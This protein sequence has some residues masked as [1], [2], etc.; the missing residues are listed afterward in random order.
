ME[1]ARPQ[2]GTRR[3][4]EFPGPPPSQ[5][6]GGRRN[7]SPHPGQGPAG[8]G[9]SPARPA[10]RGPW[11]VSPRRPCSV[12]L[13]PPPAEA[14]VPRAGSRWRRGRASLEGL[15]AASGSRCLGGHRVPRGPRGRGR[16]AARRR[17]AGPS[18][19]S[20]GRAAG[21]PGSAVS[22]ATGLLRRGPRGSRWREAAVGG[23]GRAGPGAAPQ[24][25]T[26]CIF[27]PWPQS[28]PAPRFERLHSLP[29]FVWETR[30][31]PALLA[32]SPGQNPG[33]P[34][35]DRC[36]PAS[37]DPQHLPPAP[38]PQG[39]GVKGSEWHQGRRRGGPVLPVPEHC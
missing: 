23:K 36:E 20:A 1:L 27:L 34:H 13:P 17:R 4:T 12:S 25:D 38:L 10:S 7:W 3:G 31:A 35:L 29:S 21:S 9:F 33:T 32:Q 11:R 5:R 22:R 15:A 8:E 26:T 19:V 39:S 30:R 14:A 18:G 2:W 24:K 16:R 28:L 6:M 37:P